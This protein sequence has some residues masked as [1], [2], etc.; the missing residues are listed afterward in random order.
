MQEYPRLGM[1]LRAL[2]DGVDSYPEC[3]AKASLIR[4]MTEILSVKVDEARMPPAIADLFRHPPPNNT[5]IPEV[6]SVAAHLALFDASGVREAALLGTAAELSWKMASSPMYQVLAYFTSPQRL[7]AGAAKRWEALHQGLPLT[8]EAD[9]EN[10]TAQIE[11]THAPYLWN[12][13]AHDWTAASWGPLLTM[14]RAQRGT[15]VVRRSTT[16]GATFDVDWE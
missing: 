2:P 4:L 8:I 5:W 10:K 7:L 13:L 12:S 15:I 14:S 3:L 9:N 1:Y 11:M 16:T 6:H